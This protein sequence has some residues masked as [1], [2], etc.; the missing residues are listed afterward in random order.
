MKRRLL[1]I[2]LCLCLSGCATHPMGLT[3]EQWNALTPDK[4]AELQAQQ[5]AIIAAAQQQREVERMERERV[6][7]EAAQAHAEQIRQAYA[8]AQY[9]D[10][11]TVTIQSGFVQ[12]GGKLRAIEPVS[13]DLIKGESKTIEFHGRDIRGSLGRYD[14]RLSDD[15][16]MVYFNEDF[17]GRMVLANRDWEHGENYTP[18]VGRNGDYGA[19]S[20]MRFFVKYKRLSGAPDRVIIETEGQ[21]YGADQRIRH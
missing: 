14:V 21:S 3:T 12:W 17:S 13:F 9:G 7:R 16:N 20:G 15:G 11:V 4:Q 1:I 19:P 18:I 2:F 10:V 5:Y 6:A 8:S